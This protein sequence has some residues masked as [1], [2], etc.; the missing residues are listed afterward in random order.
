MAAFGLLSIK[1][2]GTLIRGSHLTGHCDM[3]DVSRFLWSETVKHSPKFLE[4]L[5]G[6]SFHMR[7]AIR[8]LSIALVV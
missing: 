8:R 6:A 1:A 7:A 5:L 3:G 2:I 4:N